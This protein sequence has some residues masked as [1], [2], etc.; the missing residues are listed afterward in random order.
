[1]TELPYDAVLFD[2]LTALVDSW[3]LWG[4]VA[5]S[6]EAGRR[7]RGAYLEKTYAQGPYRDYEA[8][9]AEAAEE[10]GYPRSWSRELARRTDELAPWPGVTETL[11]H[12][13]ALVKIA[14]VTNCSEGLGQ[15]AVARVGVAFDVVVTAERA[16][17]YKPHPRPYELALH[18]LGVPR[19]RALFV[20]GS[21]YDLIGTDRV[22]LATVW[23]NAPGLPLPPAVVAANVAPPLGELRTIAPLADLVSPRAG[24]PR[25]SA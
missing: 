10:C 9:V 6:P 17:F 7:W 19:E 24:S 14:V 16:G 20:A 18:E 5:G 2:L 8:L 23:H 25:R 11:T 12:L 22:G 4:Q 3:T 13:K 21:A 15:R 1:M